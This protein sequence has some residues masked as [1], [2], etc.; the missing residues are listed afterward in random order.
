[1]P[2]APGAADPLV[3]ETRREIAEIVREVAGAV[4]SDR[5]ADEFLVFLVDRIL[6]AMAAEGVMVWQRLDTGPPAYRCVTRVGR[7]T[8]QRIPAESA[9][10]HTRLL[11]E[12]AGN[13]QPVVVP[14]T[15]GATAAEFPANPLEVPVALVPI[16]CERSADRSDY[17]L[18]VFLEPDC[19]VATQRGYLRFVVQMADLAGEFLR[20]DQLRR[21]RRNQSLRRH[22]DAAIARLHETEDRK[23]LEAT[24]VDG[25]ASLFGFDRVGLCLLEPH[26]KLAAVSHVNTI[27]RKSPAAKHLC[28]ASTHDLDVDRCVWFDE[29]NETDETTEEA[30]IVRAVVGSRGVPSR[31]LVCMQVAGTDPVPKECRGE[32]IRYM[33]HAEFAL[34][35]ATRLE[36]IPGGR[37][38]ASLA[39][40][41]RTNGHRGWGPI[42]LGCIALT[43]LLLAA[44]FPVPLVVYSTG[45]IRPAVVQT[46]S[47]PRDA[48]VDQVHVRH[49]QQVVRGEKLLTLVDPTLDEQITA[50]VG[51]RAVL[52]Q[53]QSQWTAALVDTASHRLDRL[54]QVQGER[55]IVAEE[56]RS[57]D[58]QLAVLQGARESLVLRADRDGFVDA[59]Q[60]EQR[61]QS[62]PLR[63]GDPLVH[64]VAQDSPWLVDV[65]VPQSRIAHVQD[66]EADQTLSARMSLEAK[67][68]ESFDASLLQIGPAVLTSEDS[69][70]STAVL[71]RLSDQASKAIAFNQGT[72][73]QSGAPARVIFRCGKTPA[74]YL[75]FQDLIRSLRGHVALYLA[76]DGEA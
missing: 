73:H 8:D 45:S 60:I 14:A 64:V 52:I 53:Q 61:L 56:I 38:L 28:Q 58:D 25:A 30:L 10:T 43:L 71:L 12:V 35:Q 75:L 33:Q 46:L 57:I 34:Q 1:M 29:T 3:N 67:P 4:R 72:N 42:A 74:A 62:R 63:R 44:C 37:L 7:I 20:A 26:V 47:A 17:L 24:I 36:A 66:A 49:G 50:L 15:P 54:E 65:R 11:L 55:S 22:I 48:V 16:E 69:V 39:P 68:S 21:L 51:R 5:T 40:L 23:Q 9:A 2:A 19:G 41:M 76:S 13:G 59:W 6:R 31:R 27:D 70:P 32:L 18:E